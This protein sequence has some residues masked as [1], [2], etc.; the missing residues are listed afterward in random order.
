MNIDNKEQ[1]LYTQ[2]NMTEAIADD[3]PEILLPL[4]APE[5]KSL[6]KMI[7]DILGNGMIGSITIIISLLILSSEN[8]IIGNIQGSTTYIVAKENTNVILR[9]F[10]SIVTYFNMGMLVCISRCLSINDHIGVDHFIK[11]NFWF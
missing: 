2:G 11:M 5:K 8:A 6:Y 9:N 4:Q 7:F 3:Q 10:N 1:N